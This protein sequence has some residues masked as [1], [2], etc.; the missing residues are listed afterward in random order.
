MNKQKLLKAL[1]VTED[2]YHTVVY[3]T[4]VAFLEAYLGA[5]CEVFINHTLRTR[6]Y[7]SWWTNQFEID[8]NRFL[9]ISID[10]SVDAWIDWHQPSRV[11][12]KPWRKALDA[13]Y[14]SMCISAMKEEVRP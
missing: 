12:A 9:D 3:N 2:F 1:G 10:I 5:D 6:A 13:G 4:G 11:I 8:A 7:W 14:E